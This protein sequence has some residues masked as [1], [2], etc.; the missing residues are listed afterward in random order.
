MKLF[1]IKNG[2]SRLKRIWSIEE[3]VQ[4]IKESY[5]RNLFKEM[6]M[7]A[8]SLTTEEQYQKWRFNQRINKFGPIKVK[9]LLRR[10]PHRLECFL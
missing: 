5:K 1:P 4:N 7:E 10:Y 6:T 3:T 8:F 9:E 2:N